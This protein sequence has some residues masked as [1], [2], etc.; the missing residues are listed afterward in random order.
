MRHPETL[1]EVLCGRDAKYE[2]LPYFFTD[3][4]D[5]GSEY[6]GFVPEELR[7]E[8]EVVVRGDMRSRELIAFFVDNHRVLAGMNINIWDEIGRASC[9]K[10][11]SAGSTM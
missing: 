11:C 10:E 6:V 2:R 9:R 3:Q 8:V 7:D 4:Y 5:L 1:A